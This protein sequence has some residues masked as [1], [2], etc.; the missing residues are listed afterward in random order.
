[1]CLEREALRKREIAF[2]T[3]DDRSLDRSVGSLVGLVDATRRR[4]EDGGFITM[5]K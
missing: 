3:I 5:E 4:G 1:M 2:A